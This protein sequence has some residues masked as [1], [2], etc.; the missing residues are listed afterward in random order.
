V[1]LVIGF[2]AA[3]AAA[4][5]DI[6]RFTLVAGAL[7]VGVGIGLQNVVN[8]FVSGLILLFERPIQLGDVVEVGQVSGTVKRIG[9][10]SSTIRTYDGAEVVIPN[11]EFVSN[12]FIN[13]TLSD[14]QRRIIVPVGIAYGTD[15][16]RVLELLLGAAKATPKVSPHPAPEAQFIGFGDSSLDFELRVWTLNFD[17]WVSVRTLLAVTVNTRLREAGIEIPFPQRDL[18]LR[19]VPQAGRGAGEDAAEEAGPEP[20]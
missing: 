15:P 11:S 9:L 1:V 10:R 17:D 7:G 5:F 19:S 16:E 18:H 3:A 12:Q 13:W 14:R 2:L 6:G 8:N 20:D 4:G